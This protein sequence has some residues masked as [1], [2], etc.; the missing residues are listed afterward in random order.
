MR[1]FPISIDLTGQGVAVIG[2]GADAVA[3]IR[4]LLKTDADI[5]VFARH[6]APEIVAWHQAGRLRHIARGFE[7]VDVASLRL[8]YISGSDAAVRDG[9]L[10][11]LKPSSVPFCVIDDLVRSRFITP[12]IIDRAPVTV[13]ISTAGTAPVLARR[14][15]AQVEDL[16]S[17]HIGI[18]ARIAGAFRPHL[19][20][21]SSGF[22]RRFWGRFF[23]VE[24]PA[25]FAESGG[26]NGGDVEQRLA[27]NMQ[28][29]L[30]ELT[31]ESA[32]SIPSVPSIA[33]LLLDSPDPELLTIKARR[34]L[35]AADMV[36]YDAAIAPGG[37][38][39]ILDY[40]R[41]EAELVI[42]HH[43]DDILR[44]HDKCRGH[45]VCRGRVVRLI[46]R[47]GGDV[48]GEMAACLDAG[49]RVQ[50]LAS[51]ADSASGTGVS[52]TGVSGTGVSGSALGTPSTTPYWQGWQPS[53]HHRPP[54]RHTESLSA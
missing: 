41:R 37:S 49:L 23:D 3:K 27:Q 25:L 47:D 43:A 14:I 28:H 39:A 1:Y 40:A 9:A 48:D 4:L 7:A 20:G 54:Q 29:L 42:A 6:P 31:H 24:A 38:S 46:H 18:C 21:F 12:A 32:P 11:L 33:F 36:I 53:P 19:A 30:A 45:P 10:A 34:V 5:R 35:A 44:A 8:A 17:P 22:R 51:L 52:G 2:G 50:R 26:G 15:K 13:A 16:L